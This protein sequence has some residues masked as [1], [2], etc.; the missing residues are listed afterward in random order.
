M[1][2]W[3]RGEDPWEAHARYFKKCPYLVKSKG[4]SWVREVNANP[5]PEAIAVENVL[6]VSNYYSPLDCKICYAKPVKVVF[7]PCK[8]LVT[9]KLCATAVSRC[10]VCRTDIASTLSV[11]LS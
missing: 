10:V 1:S 3:E 4:L 9:C 11:F 7:L 8:H 5:I 2:S 6:D